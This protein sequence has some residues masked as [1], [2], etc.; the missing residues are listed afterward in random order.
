MLLLF[1]LDGVLVDC[2]DLHREA[3]CLA[4]N[5]IYPQAQIDRTFHDQR[6]E[7]KTTKQKIAICFEHFTSLGKQDAAATATISDRKQ[8]ITKKLLASFIYPTHIREALLAAKA[9]GHTLGCCTNSIRATAETCLRGLGI[10]DLMTV[11]LSNE[12]VSAP[13]PAPEIYLKAMAA[14]G[15][16][17]ADTLIFEDSAVGLAAAAASGAATVR[18]I[19]SV[20]LTVEFVRAAVAAR[21]R[22]IPAAKHINVVIPMAGEGSRFKTAGYTI[23]K[24]FIPVHGKP[25]YKWVLDNV[26]GH[27]PLVFHLMV[28]KEH[29]SYYKD[30]PENVHLHVV[31]RLTEGAACTVLLVK[32]LISTADPLLIV[33][34]D[35]WL[36]WDVDR[37]LD[38]ALNSSFAGTISTFYQP[39]VTDLRW[40]YAAVDCDGL[41][42]RVAEKEFI[43]PHA[44]TGI[45]F[46]QHGADFVAAAEAM[47]AAGVRING[48]FYVC[49][50]YNFAAGAKRI[51]NCKRMWGLGVPADLELFLREGPGAATT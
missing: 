21:G 47:I 28:R 23:P 38:A 35:Q 6:L 8:D 37:F 50:V 15:F 43:G 32:E 1:D 2:C 31:D 29:V 46:W 45:Y 9:A 44:T 34:S 18:V 24:P 11:I 25:M 16:E 22:P 40:S 14:A 10:Y 41:V 48:E 27:W 19:D 13:K 51:M 12:D 42:S 30:V 26:T 4:W 49:P 33:N 3:F 39:V 20:D 7:A 17:A 5:T 36:D